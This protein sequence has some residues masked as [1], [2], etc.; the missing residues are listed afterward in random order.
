MAAFAMG[1]QMREEGVNAVQDTHQVDV[2]HPAPAVERD[3]IDATSSGDPGIVAQHVDIAERRERLLGRLGDACRIGDIAGH[4]AHIRAAFPEVTDSGV[5]CH[6]FD[7]CEHDF[8][9][10]SGKCLGE[11]KADAAGRA[12]HECRLAT[13]IPH[14]I[15]PYRSWFRCLFYASGAGVTRAALAAQGSYAIE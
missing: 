6:A 1:A 10:G 15:P 14:G 9:T 3:C 2:D 8:H 5:Q 12:R 11:R 13:E 7:V 4:A